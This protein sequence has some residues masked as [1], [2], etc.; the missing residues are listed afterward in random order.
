MPGINVL[1]QDGDSQFFV[2][3]TTWHI[4]DR[5]QLHLKKEVQPVASFAKDRWQAVGFADAVDGTPRAELDDLRQLRE[6]NR[7]LREINRRLDALSTNV[8]N[9][10]RGGKSAR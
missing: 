5:G 2:D 4:D 3:A 1:D 9:A 6:S 10:F 8:T 7:Q